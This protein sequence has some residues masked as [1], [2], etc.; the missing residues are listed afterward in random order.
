MHIHII[1]VSDTG[2]ITKPMCRCAYTGIGDPGKPPL[3]FGWGLIAR[4][5]QNQHG[6]NTHRILP[7]FEPPGGATLYVLLELYKDV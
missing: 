6:K 1:Y 2:Y 3:E 7:R 4:C 5:T